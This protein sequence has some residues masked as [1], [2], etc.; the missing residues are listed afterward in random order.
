MGGIGQLEAIVIPDGRYCF[1]LLCY[2]LGIAGGCML[3]FVEALLDMY[4]VDMAFVMGTG[5]FSC[6]C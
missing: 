5:I 1:S 4:M 6:I 2:A 3:F